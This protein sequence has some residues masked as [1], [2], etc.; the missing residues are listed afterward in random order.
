MQASE[1]ARGTLSQFPS[2]DNNYVASYNKLSTNHTDIWQHNHYAGTQNQTGRAPRQAAHNLLTA[3]SFLTT[4]NQS[5]LSS[6]FYTQIYQDLKHLA[7]LLYFKRTKNKL[8]HQS[9]KKESYLYQLIASMKEL[10]KE[11]Q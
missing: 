9:Q 6:P 8:N 7:S 5:N 1:Q 4:Q 10:T 11:L 3:V 2:E